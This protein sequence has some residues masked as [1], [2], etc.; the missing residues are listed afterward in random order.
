MTTIT[1]PDEPVTLA[2]VVLLDISLSLGN[3]N[4][5]CEVHPQAEP[6]RSILSVAATLEE[7]T[8]YT[9]RRVATKALNRAKK[10][11]LVATSTWRVEAVPS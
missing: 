2:W 8:R 11:A 3:Q 6:K 4:Y 5:L 9:D 7:A 10:L 1:M